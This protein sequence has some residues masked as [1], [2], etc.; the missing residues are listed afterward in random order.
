MV[1]AAAA[2]A[3]RRRAITAA[4]MRRVG[5][6]LAEGLARRRAHVA[7]RDRRGELPRRARLAAERVVGVVRLV[8]E[9]LE[10]HVGAR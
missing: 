1:A 7:L 10:L 3:A 6:Q 9:L 2:A 5:R 4:A 8:A